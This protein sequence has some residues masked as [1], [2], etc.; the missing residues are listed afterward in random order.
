MNNNRNNNGLAWLL[1]EAIL[2]RI[3]KS[4]A[5]IYEKLDLTMLIIDTT[6]AMVSDNRKDMEIIEKER[7]AAQEL[8][9]QYSPIIDEDRLSVNEAKTNFNIYLDDITRIVLL[10]IYKNDL[11]NPSLLQE[12][13]AVKWK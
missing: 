5:Q 1:T 11:I 9:R 2:M 3:N 10:I 8:R 6:Y 12:V 7:A 13:K 4:G